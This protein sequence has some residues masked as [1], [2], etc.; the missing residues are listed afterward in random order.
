VDDNPDN[1]RSGTPVDPARVFAALADFLYQGADTTEVCAAICVAATL[2]VPGCDHASV[3]MRR[4]DE[5]VT[6]AASDRIARHVDSLERATGEGPCLDAIEDE[7]AQVEPDLAN[8]RS[9]PQLVARVVLETPVRGAMGFRILV[10]NRKV[11]ALNLFSD[12]VNRFDTTA[13][14]RA[15][16]LAA[17]ASVAINAATS[18]EDVEGLRQGLQ[19]NRE[20]GRAVGMLMLLKDV[21]Q[22]EA[23]DMLRRVSQEMNIKV[24]EVARAVVEQRGQLPSVKPKRQDP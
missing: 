13:T 16:V 1:A 5:F 8:S 11:G 19:S 3:L 10:N 14:E 24:A 12:T 2:L 20:I 6:V 4:N 18:G 9:W 22:E 23:F 21:T 17:F 15:I 7:A